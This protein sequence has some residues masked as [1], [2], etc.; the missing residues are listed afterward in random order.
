MKSGIDVADL[1]VLP[2]Q[3]GFGSASVGPSSRW[4]PRLGSAMLTLAV[5]PAEAAAERI[6]PAGGSKEISSAEND[7]R[8]LV[9]A[10]KGLSRRRPGSQVRLHCTLREHRQRRTGTQKRP[11]NLLMHESS[12]FYQGK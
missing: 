9:D 10:D 3:P 4:D 1:R 2:L 6:N 7:R 11:Q 12:T 5:A 8:W